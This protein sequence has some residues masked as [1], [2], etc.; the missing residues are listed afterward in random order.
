MAVEKSK[1]DRRSTRLA[2]AIPVTVSG[3]DAEGKAFS[4][5]VRTVVINKHG[6]KIA[7]TTPLAMGAT[8]QIENH[9]MRAAA[10]ANVV[11]VGDAAPA[12]ELRQV[13]LQL[14]EAQNVWGIAFPPDDWSAENE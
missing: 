14:T 1:L 2:I 6:G 11:W 8:V 3:T 7:I 12:G 4:E 5:N 13:G 10:K 9:A